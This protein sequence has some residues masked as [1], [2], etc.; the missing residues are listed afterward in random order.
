[1]DQ[2]RSILDVASMGLGG[3]IDGRGAEASGLRKRADQ[4]PFSEEGNTGREEQG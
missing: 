1:M 3:G 4:V 2:P